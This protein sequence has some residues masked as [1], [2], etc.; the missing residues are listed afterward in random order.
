L[1]VPVPES[2]SR[3]A[4]R[5]L[6][7]AGDDAGHYKAALCTAALLLASEEEAADSVLNEYRAAVAREAI[8]IRTSARLTPEADR[9]LTAIW[10]VLWT[11]LERAL[12][13]RTA[14]LR[15]LRRAL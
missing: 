11:D 2:A 15:A 9:R 12:P 14:Q 1:G 3:D 7:F 5:A 10:D 8:A 13:T 6:A 4:L